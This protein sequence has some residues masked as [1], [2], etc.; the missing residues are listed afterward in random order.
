MHCG[1]DFTWK[2]L[3]RNVLIDLQKGLH[4]L[5]KPKKV[6]HSKYKVGRCTVL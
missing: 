6:I 4:L 3:A 5:K 1:K 2:N